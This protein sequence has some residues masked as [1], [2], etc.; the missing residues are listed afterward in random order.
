MV[1]LKD[2]FVLL[3]IPHPIFETNCTEVSKVQLESY[4]LVMAKLH[5]LFARPTIDRANVIPRVVVMHNEEGV[6]QLRGA[7]AR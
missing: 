5:D 7:L 3:V 6:V 1:R 4:H 2:T